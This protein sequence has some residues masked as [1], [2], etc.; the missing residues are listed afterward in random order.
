VSA[1]AEIV[2]PAAFLLSILI[3]TS[4]DEML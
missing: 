2:V 1:G 3:L 4:G